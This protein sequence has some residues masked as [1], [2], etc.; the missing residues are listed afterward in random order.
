[1]RVDVMSTTV[2]PFFAATA[3]SGRSLGGRSAVM[4]VPRALA[5]FEF[6]MRTGMLRAT[7]GWMVA[8]CRTLAPK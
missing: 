8:G 3:V 1:M 2:T 6:R 7:A 4:S 5:R